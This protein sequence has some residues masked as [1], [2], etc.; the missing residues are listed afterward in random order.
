MQARLQHATVSRHGRRDYGL[1]LDVARFFPP[2]LL[3]DRNPYK[4]SCNEVRYN[5]E[6]Y[7]TTNNIL[8]PSALYNHIEPSFHTNDQ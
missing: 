5:V 3:L 1:Y 8:A 7:K 2:N 4:P 6:A